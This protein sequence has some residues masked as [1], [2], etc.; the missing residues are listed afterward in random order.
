MSNQTETEMSRPKRLRPVRALIA[1]GV[2]LLLGSMGVVYGMKSGGKE[3][4]AACA[5]TATTI[6]RIDPMIHGEVA[7]LSLAKPAAMMPELTFTGAD[8]SAKTL[9]DFRGKTVL[10]NL[11]ATWCVPCRKEM[12]ALDRLQGTLGGPD[13]QVVAVNIDTAKLDRP[14]QFLKDIGVSHLPFYADPT[15]QIFQTLRENGPILGLPTTFLLDRNGCT[16]ATMAGPAEWD[17]ADAQKV[18]EAAKS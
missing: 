11:W 9:A 8:G 14:K 1:A 16:I 13:F 6:N 15:A 17:S 7:A 18:I 10:L 3:A 2:V 4:S 5:G 12:P